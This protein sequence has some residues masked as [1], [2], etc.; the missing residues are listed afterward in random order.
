MKQVT[1]EITAY[2]TMEV[3]DDFDVSMI[4]SVVKSH[5]TI[6]I[7]T[8]FPNVNTIEVSDIINVSLSHINNM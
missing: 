2:V 6:D 8:D 3:P 7:T 1:C 5:S 4:P